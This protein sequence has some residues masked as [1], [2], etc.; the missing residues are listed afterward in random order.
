MKIFQKSGVIR[1]SFYLPENEIPRE[2][3]RIIEKD[4]KMMP[5]LSAKYEKKFKEAAEFFYKTRLDR[6][7]K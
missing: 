6:V 4:S 5:D 2:K 3:M 1:N 7:N